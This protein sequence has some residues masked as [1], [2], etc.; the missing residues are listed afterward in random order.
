MAKRKLIA[1]TLAATGLLGLGYLF[2]DSEQADEA[3]STRH[4]KNQVWI[5]RMPKSQRDMVGHLAFIKHPRG[6]IGVAGRSSQWR[7]FIELMHW[8]LS[9]STLKVYMPQDEIRTEVEVR[10]WK[11]EGEAP[12]P[13]E[14]CLELSA[15]GRKVVYY[16]RKDW[17]IDP[18]DAHDSVQAL[19]ED[20]PELEAV[21]EHVA[22]P[23][24]LEGGFE[25]APELEDYRR[26]D[27]LLLE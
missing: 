18:K 16:S 7:H 22:G 13:F 1:L 23:E 27:S 20:A 21:F 15:K 3:A 25:S 17:V 5:E 14:L 4:F 26:V 6:R 12:K 24:A 9:G 8:K 11:C 2:G 19:V 10:T